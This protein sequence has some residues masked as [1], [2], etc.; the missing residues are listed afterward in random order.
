M[1]DDSLYV[2]LKVHIYMDGNERKPLR[3]ECLSEV[4]LRCQN[5]KLKQETVSTFV[6]YMN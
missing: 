2:V 4:L 1:D 6:E 5:R 3:D